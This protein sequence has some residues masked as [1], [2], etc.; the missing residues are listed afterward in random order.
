VKPGAGVDFSMTSKLHE[1]A[2]PPNATVKIPVA[3]VDAGAVKLRL[4]VP[5]VNPNAT[6]KV[7]VA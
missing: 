7:L 3:L 2:A 1:Q 6:A 5:V 4:P